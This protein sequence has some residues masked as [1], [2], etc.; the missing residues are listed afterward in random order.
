MTLQSNFLIY[1][2]FKTQFHLK[3]VFSDLNAYRR[4]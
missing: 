3:A 1:F 2:L 4:F